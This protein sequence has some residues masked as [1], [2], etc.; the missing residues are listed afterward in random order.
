MLDMTAHSA[1]ANSPGPNG[2][3]KA[4]GPNGIDGGDGVS[5]GDIGPPGFEFDTEKSSDDGGG[6]KEVGHLRNRIYE[7]SPGKFLILIIRLT[8][9][10][11]LLVAYRIV[12]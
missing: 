2:R 6:N 12:S 7:A 9:T 1:S 3:D 8:N 10:I 11:F 4:D 5:D